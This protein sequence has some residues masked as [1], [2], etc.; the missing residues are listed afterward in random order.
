MARRTLGR[1]LIE[2]LAGIPVRVDYGSEFR[3]RARAAAEALAL[4]TISQSGETADTLTALR[5]IRGQGVRTLT[6]C[7]VPTSSMVRESDDALLTLVGPEIGVASTKAFTD[8]SSPWPSWP[9]TGAWRE[10]R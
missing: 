1:Y 4:L 3:G 5:G 6:V 8:R 9:P 7:N 2:G 10:G